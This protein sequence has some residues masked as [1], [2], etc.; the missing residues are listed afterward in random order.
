MNPQ[1]KIKE[2]R[3]LYK[4]FSFFLTRVAILTRL[5]NSCKGARLRSINLWKK[6]K[7]SWKAW[8]K[9]ISIKKHKRVCV[10][11]VFIKWGSFRIGGG[12]YLIQGGTCLLATKYFLGGKWNFLANLARA[13]LSCIMKAKGDDTTKTKKL[14]S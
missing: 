10:L 3:Y 9:Y 14:H 4:P 1:D 12:F 13:Q 11:K 5:I 6:F 8:K 7:V 2:L